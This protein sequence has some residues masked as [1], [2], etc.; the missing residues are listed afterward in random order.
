M[1]RPLVVIISSREEHSDG[2]APEGTDARYV[3]AVEAAGG[4]V[5]LIPWHLEA[6]ELAARLARAEGLV[7]T[8][9]GDVDPRHYCGS[10]ARKC[11]GVSA[12]R[13][14]VDRAAVEFALAHPELPVLGICRGIQAYNVFAGGTL[15]QDI[16]SDKPGCLQ[17]HQEAPEDQPSHD[18]RI[19]DIDSL[20]AGIFG[21]DRVAVNSFHHQAVKEVAPGL[22][23]TARAPDGVIEALEDPGARW[24]VLV[25][26]H[27]E[28][29]LHTDPAAARLF[30]AF[31]AAC[32]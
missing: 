14:A 17:H 21:E 6:R 31:V 8:G 32:R 10:E 26:W 9:G 19:T 12:A 2:A 30:E 3:G 7:L 18:I 27:P 13:D 22:A 16:P 28:R 5:D 1:R 23:V 25:Q 15:I 4:D 29:M 24:R 20:L 11:R